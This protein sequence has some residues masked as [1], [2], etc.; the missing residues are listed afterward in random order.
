[1]EVVPQDL[2]EYWQGLN[3]KIAEAA[4]IDDYKTAA[5]YQ[6]EIITLC[7]E[8]NY[9]ARLFH[10]Y[11][12]Y[13]QWKFESRDISAGNAYIDSTEQLYIKSQM[14]SLRPRLYMLKAQN[15]LSSDSALTFYEMAL[16][17]SAYLP[18]NYKDALLSG[19]C[20]S[21]LHKGYYQEAKVYIPR[22][23]QLGS[24]NPNRSGRLV[25]EMILYQW[26]NLIEMELKDTV[27]AFDAI[28]TAHRILEDSL[29]GKGNSFV[30]V[31]LGDYYYDVKQYDSALYY[32][33]KHEAS[34]M[35]DEDRISMIEAHM[36]KALVYTAICDFKKADEAI[37]FVETQGVPSLKEIGYLLADYHRTKYAVDKHFGRMQQALAALEETAR[38]EDNLHD[39]QK[40]QQLEVLEENLTRARAEKTIAEKEQEINRQQVYTFSFLIAAVLIS[41]I[42]VL[43]VVNQR[44]KKMI[45]SQRMKTLEQ[46]A[47]IEKGQ[48]RID[49][50]NEERK[51]ISKEMHDD[52]GPALTTLSLAANMIQQEAGDESG[53]KVADVI[54]KNASI[55]GAQMNEIVWSLNSGNDNLNSLTAYIRKYATAFFQ[56]N[57]TPVH[58][59]I[60]IGAE[61]IILD[62]HKRRS[63]YQAVKEVLTI[64]GKYPTVAVELNMKREGDLLSINIQTS[65]I[66]EVLLVNMS[67]TGG[68]LVRTENGVEMKM[69]LAP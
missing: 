53:K 52:I 8:R 11:F 61:N 25:G 47:I 30:F 67:E 12:M 58:F 33:G 3:E 2:A 21:Y 62:G 7:K 34:L 41:S 57:G 60:D 40:S 27:A 66:E 65:C 28:S 55:L 39:Q 42:G 29:D 24:L 45:E 15:I 9:I 68:M 23:F 19:L 17:D 6:D 26:L 20:A 43:L 35:E 49:A 5:R 1:M 69:P 38:L 16:E 56:V 13:A 48:V 10:A 37:R 32:Y 18:D 22:L 44:R 64:V 54:Q 59:N 4:A 51:R 63:I 50:E 14:Q 31:S 46:E 36:R